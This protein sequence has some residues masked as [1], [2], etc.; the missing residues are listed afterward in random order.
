MDK[1][2][3]LDFIKKYKVLKFAGI[4]LIMLA[5]CPFISKLLAELACEGFLEKLKEPTEG[6][7]NL[8]FL[9][10]WVFIVFL[11]VRDI[12]YFDITGR[13]NF[14]KDARK[15]GR[16]WN[17]LTTYYKNAEPHKL[18]IST[19]KEERW[20]QSEGVFFGVKDGRL[21]KI[22][23][24][25]EANI[26][27]FGTPGSSK[28]TGIAIPTAS[29]FAGSVFAIDIK[30]DIYNYTHRLR[31]IL[32]FSPDMD[33]AIHQSCHYNPFHGINN[34]DY[35]D[36]KLF[37]EN[38]AITLIPD[39]HGSDGNY[40]SSTARDM[41]QGIVHYMLYLNPNTTFPD[42]LHAILH[43]SKDNDLPKTI[44]EWITKIIGS[45]CNLAKER[46]SS[47]YGNNEKNISGGFNNLT[48]ALVPLSNSVLDELL[49]DSPT[50]YSISIN[51]LEKGYDV[52]IQVKQ[53]NLHVYAP[54]FTLIT[55][56]FM[57]AFTKRPDSSTGY[58]NKP[59]LM[60][61]DEFPQLTFSLEQINMALSTLRSK[62]VICMLIAQNMAQLEK[63]YEDAGA[64]SMLG[65]CTYQLI[66][67]CI[68][69]KS[70]KYFSDLIGTKKVLVMSNNEN[71]GTNLY[72]GTTGQSCVEQREPVYFPEDFGDL[73]RELIIYFKG[74]YTKATKIRSY[75]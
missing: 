55:Q 42:V 67:S 74:K 69:G 29:R 4:G 50:Q 36:R 1:K 68:D 64:R 31:H 46:V 38:M 65:N 43:P 72:N 15:F 33:D 5:V 28:T 66:L 41:F 16:S 49:K 18:D 75:E 47:L 59:I 39:E 73:E 19:F 22:P 52:Y 10:L 12:V 48:K 11:D 8:I 60:L 27:V 9:G 40:F 25:S 21:I 61:L 2:K 13:K 7:L 71:S 53:E 32:R 6:I 63:K 58:R 30:G 45:D 34:M 51:A 54:L 57:T 3:I 70:Q 26:A 20:K 17:E 37:V 62:S 44:F 56:S 24:N 35:T 23:S 14:L